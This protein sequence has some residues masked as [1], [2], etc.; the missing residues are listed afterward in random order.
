MPFVFYAAFG[1]VFSA[2]FSI[3]SIKIPYPS[4]GA[5]TIMYVTAPTSLPSWIIGLP[6]IPRTMPPV[7]A[8]RASSVA[9]LV[10]Y[11]KFGR[12][13]LT[14]SCV[15]ICVAVGEKLR[16]RIRKKHWKT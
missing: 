6:D 1:M 10:R 14:V 8:I 16:N 7:M 15:A 2:A 13:Q 9:L 5:A 4:V 11:E 3:F 12:R